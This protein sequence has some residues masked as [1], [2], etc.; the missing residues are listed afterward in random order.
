[1]WTGSALDLTP[2]P[3]RYCLCHKLNIKNH[4]PLTL[5]SGTPTEDR[6]FCFFNDFLLSIS[7]FVH[8]LPVWDL[9]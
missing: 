7:E 8:E 1:M 2:D 3:P 4:S 5:D 6:L 9:L